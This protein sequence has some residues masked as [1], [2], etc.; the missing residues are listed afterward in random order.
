MVVGWLARL[1]VAL[2]VLGVL[3]LDGFAWASARVTAQDRA[4]AAGRAASSAYAGTA[5][6]QRAY[7]AALA[8][9]S[10]QGDAIDPTTFTATADGTVT[11]TLAHE[12]STLVLHRVPRLERLTLLSAT[13]TTAPS[14]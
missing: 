2:S 10:G 11:L 14:P 4:E 1:V 12:A 13:V 9:V 3:A 7:D 6:V 8:E 5:D